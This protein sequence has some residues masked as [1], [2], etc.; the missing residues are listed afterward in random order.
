VRSDDSLNELSK[1][2]YYLTKCLYHT[3][4]D[5]HAVFPL[6]SPSELNGCSLRVVFFYLLNRVYKDENGKK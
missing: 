2:D 1:T 3:S 6:S 5:N 4:F